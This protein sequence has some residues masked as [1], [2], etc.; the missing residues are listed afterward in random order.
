MNQGI[1]TQCEEKKKEELRP[2]LSFPGLFQKIYY[3]IIF[4]NCQKK[5]W[6]DDAHLL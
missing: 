3:Y 4:L 2:L 6:E 5:S 1:K